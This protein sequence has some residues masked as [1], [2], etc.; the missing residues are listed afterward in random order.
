V[1]ARS[2][3]LQSVVAGVGALL[4][5][6]WPVLLTWR[7]GA[8]GSVGDLSEVRFLGLGIVYSLGL[9]VLAGRLMHGAL[10]AARTAAHLRP[11]DPWGAYA[12]GLGV[13][14][15]TLSAL[16][17]LILLLLLTDEDQSLRSREWLVYLLWIA[18]HLG[19]AAL[20]VAAAR[21]LLRSPRSARP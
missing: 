4:V 11:L 5:C 14:T 7:A 18:G 10:T 8:S 20:A 3:L 15:L 9:A 1:T 2:R 6:I 17:G 12:L 19:A 16:L 21:A 13:F